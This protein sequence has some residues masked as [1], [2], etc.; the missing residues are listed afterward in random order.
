[1]ERVRI[2][3]VKMAL[4]S[5]PVFFLGGIAF[6]LHGGPCAGECHTA[7]F[8][9]VAL[10]GPLLVG[11]FTAALGFLSDGLAQDESPAPRHARSST[12]STRNE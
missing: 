8:W 2:A 6:T 12:R 3:P 1:M 10:G 4:L 7:L 5:F 11:V 9:R